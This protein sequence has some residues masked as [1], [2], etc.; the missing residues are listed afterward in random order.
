L[1]TLTKTKGA[2]IKY[3]AI[4]SSLSAGV[5]NGGVYAAQ[6]TSF[7]ALLAQQMGIAN[8]KQPLLDGNGTGNKSV[9]VDKNG[10]LKFTELKD[11][12]DSKKDTKLPKVAD[13]D[14][15]AVPYQ[16]ILDIYEP[17]SDN[18]SFVDKKSFN[19]LERF[20]TIGE[21]KI[22]YLNHGKQN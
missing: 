10:V 21:D 12:D 17:S 16:K 2:S 3:V 6:Q 22:S 18:H 9:L 20:I 5:R 11:F 4:G 13:S 8:F 1:G 19:H 14:N 15:L 7:P